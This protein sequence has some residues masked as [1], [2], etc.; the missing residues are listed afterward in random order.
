MRCNFTLCEKLSH[1]TISKEFFSFALQFYTV[2][3]I[4]TW[5]NFKSVLFL[6]C[7]FTLCEKL[8]HGIILKVFFSFALQL[9]V[10]AKKRIT[11]NNQLLHEVI[12]STLHFKFIPCDEWSHRT[13]SCHFSWEESTLC[14]KLSHGI[15]LKM[16]HWN[17]VLLLCF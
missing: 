13:I 10:S 1:G 2:W 3:K 15:I 16:L 12:T 9:H 14:E 7:N 6:R 4:V 5:N 11:L 8:S 17:S